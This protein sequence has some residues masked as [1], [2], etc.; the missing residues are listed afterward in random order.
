MS[1]EA[2]YPIISQPVFQ[3]YIW[4]G[5]RLR[6][7]LGKK[8]DRD[9]ACMAESW[10]LS[11]HPHGQ[12]LVA[13]GPFAGQTFAAYLQ[14]M[15][16][17]VLGNHGKTDL[18]I[19][20]KYLDVRD[21]LSVQVHPDDA[22]AAAHEHG[23]RGKT[24]MWYIVDADPDSYIYYG[25][26]H[27]MTR[28]QFADSIKNNTI[29]KNLRKINVHPGEFVFIDS[30]TLHAAAKNCL[31]A[32]IQQNCDLTYRVYDYDRRG[33]DG[34]P[35]E[36]HIDKALDVTTL[37]PVPMTLPQ[38][39]IT[40]SDGNICQVLVSCPYFAVAKLTLTDHYRSTVT[41]DTFQTI[42]AISGQFSLQQGGQTYDLPTGTT[43]FLPAN[44]G[45]YQI[46]GHGELLLI[47][48]A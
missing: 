47:T 35:R 46:A 18:D 32:E 5:W 39:A 2:L 42:M 10:E 40:I 11:T 48:Q 41:P 20:I 12:S 28:Q 3:D 8:P 21:T 38:T 14:A 22:Y 45:D 34:Q 15:G 23:G 1:K 44:L 13:N 30:G 31:I 37:T 7:R 24:E 26:D 25:F 29:E 36:L 27:T 4:G 9:L 16:P 17:Q 33:P 43:V 19:L 6:D